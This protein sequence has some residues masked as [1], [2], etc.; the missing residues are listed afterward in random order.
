M[1]RISKKEDEIEEIFDL[2]KVGLV[3]A[4]RDRKVVHI[5][6]YMKNLFGG[7][8]NPI[9]RDILLFHEE[10]SREK[11]KKIYSKAKKGEVFQ[12]PIIKLMFKKN[13]CFLLVRLCPV[14]DENESF[15]GIVGVFYDL[16]DIVTKKVVDH[17]KTS[18]K[19]VKFPIYIDNK[20][21]L[22]EISDISCVFSHKKGSIIK[23]KG[24]EKYFTTMRISYMESE[25]SSYGFFRISGSCLLNIKFIKEI[26]EESDKLHAKT[27]FGDK[28]AISK[29]KL[30]ILKKALKFNKK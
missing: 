12:Y 30:R 14:I 25:F 29:R 9:G 17:S 5:N 13:S 26:I 19:I 16:T 1:F 8:F 11:I 21:I 4:D 27:E 7:N 20:I 28:I 24:G 22:I 6:S 2:V 10:K 18:Y 23:V 15:S 3:V